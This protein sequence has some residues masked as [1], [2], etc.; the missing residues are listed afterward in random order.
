M[1]GG[2][3]M[4]EEYAILVSYAPSLSGTPSILA[5]ETFLRSAM[6]NGGF[7][8]RSFSFHSSPKLGEGDH[9]WWRSIFIHFHSRAFGFN[10]SPKLGEG[11][12]LWWRSIFIHF[13][14]RSFGFNSSPKLGE[15][16]HLWWRSMRSLFHTPPPYRAP[17]LS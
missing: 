11:D 3:F 4:V 7:H 6:K 12:H 1:G 8:P 10:S 16:D 5:G 9:L 13:H 2:P 14:S 15:G 17:P